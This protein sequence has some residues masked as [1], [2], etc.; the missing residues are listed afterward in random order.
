MQG[1]GLCVRGDVFAGHYG[2]CDCHT[3]LLKDSYLPTCLGK[4]YSIFVFVTFHFHMHV[5]IMS[6]STCCNYCLRWELILCAKTHNTAWNHLK[7]LMFK[8]SYF[9][10]IVSILKDKYTEIQINIH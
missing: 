3:L 1:G 8:L 9:Q 6:T 4:Y 2:T 5:C 10:L 7:I